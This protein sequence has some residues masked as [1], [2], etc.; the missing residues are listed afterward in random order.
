MGR[1]EDALQ[2]PLADEVL[3]N[4]CP[5]ASTRKMGCGVAALAMKRG[6]SVDLTGCATAGPCN[7]GGKD[8]GFWLET[9]GYIGHS[10]TLPSGRGLHSG[11]HEDDRQAARGRSSARSRASQSA[12]ARGRT[13]EMQAQASQMMNL[14]EVKSLTEVDGRL[15]ALARRADL[16]ARLIK[17]RDELLGGCGPRP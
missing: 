11:H 16:E 7:T 5:G 4:C 13:V 2:R 15:R 17:A 1:S 12:R 9:S 6:K 14:F 3:K 10:P 8:A